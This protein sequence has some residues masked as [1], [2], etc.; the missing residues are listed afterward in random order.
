[1]C[2]ST[3]TA[4]RV[5]WDIPFNA[6]V[7]SVKTIT[8]YKV[9]GKGNHWPCIM[10]ASTGTASRVIWD[11]PFNASVHSVKTITSYKVLGKGYHWPCIMCGI[12]SLKAIVV[13]SFQLFFLPIH[14]DFKKSIYVYH[15]KDAIYVLDHSNIRQTDEQ[16][17]Y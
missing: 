1:M 10:C 13:S 16:I 15:S 14:C 4:S 6:S 17:F 8:L 2:A 5:I 12:T 3:G 11:I 7:H 9:L